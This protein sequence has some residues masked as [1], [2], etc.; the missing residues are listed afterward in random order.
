MYKS[1]LIDTLSKSM[2]ALIQGRENNEPINHQ[3]HSIT[4]VEDSDNI[5][6]TISKKKI[7]V[8]LICAT[9]KK[10]DDKSCVLI[11]LILLKIKEHKN[12]IRVPQVFQD[13]ESSKFSSNSSSS[14]TQN[15]RAVHLKT[16]AH[17]AYDIEFGCYWTHWKDIPTGPVS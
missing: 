14:L 6:I 3:V 12:H 5:L 8:W 16:D 15:P 1:N 4:Y 9:M 10:M 11:G 17:V 13:M 7:F 2:M